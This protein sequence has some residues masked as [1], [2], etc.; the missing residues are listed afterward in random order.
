MSMTRNDYTDNPMI[1]VVGLRPGWI[2]YELKARPRH[3]YVTGDLLEWEQGWELNAKGD[4]RRE[5]ELTEE[6]RATLQD[7]LDEAP[8]APSPVASVTSDATEESGGFFGS[9]RDG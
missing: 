2:L 9:R 6:E 7:A 5:F 8:E 4:L 3:V 1:K